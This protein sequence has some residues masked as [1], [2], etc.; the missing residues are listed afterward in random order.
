MAIDGGVYVGIVSAAVTGG[1]VYLV[2]RNRT[3]DSRDAALLRSTAL[4]SD[5]T[6]AALTAWQGIVKANTQ[7]LATQ[8]SQIDQLRNRADACEE[9]ERVLRDQLATLKAGT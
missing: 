6:R 4:Q 7:Q 3:Q 1:G 9:R 5:D 2:Q 8:E